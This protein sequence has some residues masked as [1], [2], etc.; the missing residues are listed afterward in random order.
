LGIE[1]SKLNNGIILSQENYASNILRRVGMSNCKPVSTPLSI[2]EKLSLHE[3]SLLG[4]SD[5]TQYRSA[6]GALQ[7]L[8]LT[9]P[10]ISFSVNKVC[11]Y[12]HTPITVHW[13]VVKMI[14]RYIKYTTKAG[15]HIN[16]S[17]SL[18]VSALCRLG[19]VLG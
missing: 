9:R 1:V 6:V 18:L 19:R 15:L 10:N 7:D 11:Q 8:T 4:P 14:L 16:K 2:S 17:S 13:A 3:G 5:A 12:L